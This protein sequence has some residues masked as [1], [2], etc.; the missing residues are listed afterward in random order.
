MLSFVQEVI[1]A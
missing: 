1:T